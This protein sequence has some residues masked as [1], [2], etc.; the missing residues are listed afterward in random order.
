MVGYNNLK[1]RD[2]PLEKLWG[3]VGEG[4]KKSYISKEK[5][6]EIQLGVTLWWTITHLGFSMVLYVT[7]KSKRFQI[8]CILKPQI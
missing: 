3:Q 4:Q 6:N 8:T 1:V 7:Y 5:L 2:G